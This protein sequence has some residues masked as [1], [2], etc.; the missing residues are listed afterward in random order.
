[1]ALQVRMSPAKSRKAASEK[2][3]KAGGKARKTARPKA[4]K[5]KRSAPARKAGKPKSA[6]AAKTASATG[7]AHCAAT[8]PF[9]DACQNLPR[10]PSKYCVIHSYLDR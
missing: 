4:A 10:R 7:H 3:R 9:G 2:A 8:D 6:K 1:M 5:A